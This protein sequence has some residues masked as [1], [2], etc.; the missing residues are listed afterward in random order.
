MNRRTPLLA[1]A[2][3]LDIATGELTLLAENP[4]TVAGWFASRD[5]RSVRLLADRR[6]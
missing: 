3:E 4:G 5:G 1:D 2:Y 6:R